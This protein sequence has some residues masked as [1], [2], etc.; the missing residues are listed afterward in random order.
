MVFNDQYMQRGE[1]MWEI[2]MRRT[3]ERAWWQSFFIFY[4]MRESFFGKKYDIP[5]GM[6]TTEFNERVLNWN[7]RER[8]SANTESSPEKLDALEMLLETKKIINGISLKPDFSSEENKKELEKRKKTAIKLLN[9]LI[10]KDGYIA[11]YASFVNLYEKA[12]VS[13]IERDQKE[14]VGIDDARTHAHNVLMSHIQMTTRYIYE[15]FSA[16]SE[17]ELD[18]LEER[19]QSPDKRLLPVERV[20]FPGKGHRKIFLPRYASLDDR[21]SITRWTKEIREK[22]SDVKGHF[23]SQ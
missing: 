22:F 4:Y 12:N 8:S 18:D 16:M 19:L 11:R 23:I 21:V 6:S 1:R 17:D 20:S 9:D 15:Q 7:K 13:G 2:K 3:E 10:K 14:F 5:Q